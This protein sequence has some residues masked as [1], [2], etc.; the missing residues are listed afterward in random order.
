MTETTATS[1]SGTPPGGVVRFRD[2]LTSGSKVKF[3]LWWLLTVPTRLKPL[4]TLSY[5]LNVEVSLLLRNGDRLFFRNRDDY[6]VAYE[7]FLL[8][9]YDVPCSGAR[10]VL[11]LG[12]HAGFTALHFARRFPDARIIV[13]EPDH[14]RANQIRK[15]VRANQLERRVSV[16]EAAAA[17]RNGKAR[18]STGGSSA[19]IGAE[20][21]EVRLVDVFAMLGSD[22]VD[23]LKMDIEGGEYE[24][25]SDPRFETLTPPIVAMEWHSTPAHADGHQWCL[26]RL[27]NLGYHISDERSSF[28]WAG[29]LIAFRN[30]SRRG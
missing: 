25:L 6:G 9:P 26:Q 13:M 8:G 23:V 15:H 5:S 3:L 29:N 19:R 1:A 12:G 16:I 10:L 18:L 24:I 11:D 7:V 30:P 22:Q 4:K 28:S 27:R 20:G 17:A 21:E 2:L 14:Q